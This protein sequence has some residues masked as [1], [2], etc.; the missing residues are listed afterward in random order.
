MLTAGRVKKYIL[1][2]KTKGYPDD[3]P[4]EVPDALMKLRL[5]PSY[6]A[7]ALAILSND[8]GLSSL[9]FA[10]KPSKWYSHFKR[11]E[12]DAREAAKKETECD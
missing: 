5:A 11:I 10:L 3:I 9:G 8:V 12:L 7:I 4:D 2:W 1:D 6:K